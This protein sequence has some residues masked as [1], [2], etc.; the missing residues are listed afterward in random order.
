MYY[1][2]PH[3]DLQRRRSRQIPDTLHLIRLGYHFLPLK[4]VSWDMRTI[5]F[6]DLFRIA[7]APPN[8]GVEND[9]VQWILDDITL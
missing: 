3:H 7:I 5:I 2:V 6:R 4:N 1:A 8:P 9:D